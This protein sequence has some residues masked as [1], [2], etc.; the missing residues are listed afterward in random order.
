[1]LQA[2]FDALGGEDN[3]RKLIEEDSPIIKKIREGFGGRI[4][5]MLTGS[6]PINPKV[7]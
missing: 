5:W 1:M 2:I 7:I 3:T 4:K 6:A